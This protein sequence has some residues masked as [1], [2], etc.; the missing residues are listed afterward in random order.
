MDRSA[1]AVC[2]R[3]GIVSIN[4]VQCRNEE[5]SLKCFASPVTSS[6]TDPIKPEEDGHEVPP[7]S[8]FGYSSAARVAY[9]TFSA[10]HLFDVTRKV[11]VQKMCSIYDVP[12]HELLDVAEYSGEKITEGMGQLFLTLFMALTGLHGLGI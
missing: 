10:A 9:P 7:S 1:P 5:E 3:K 12:F 6:R 2:G 8:S 4:A 11:D